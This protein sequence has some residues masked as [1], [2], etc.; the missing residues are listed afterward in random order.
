MIN[1]VLRIMRSILNPLIPIVLLI[2]FVLC[3][4]FARC[5]HIIRLCTL[6][7]C[8]LHSRYSLVSLTLF[9]HCVH[10][11][12]SRRYSHRVIR[13]NPFHNTGSPLHSQSAGNHCAVLL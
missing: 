7:F 13:I 8:F 12:W 2:L 4:L 9:A 6:V 5:I 1:Q 10:V 11:I 3:T